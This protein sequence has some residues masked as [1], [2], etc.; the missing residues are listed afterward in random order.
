MKKKKISSWCGKVC[1]EVNGPS[2]V[3]EFL[4]DPKKV[5]GIHLDLS[6]EH[7]SFIP[8]SLAKKKKQKKNKKTLIYHQSQTSQGCTWSIIKTGNLLQICWEK[9]MQ[10]W[11]MLLRY[12][13]IMLRYRKATSNCI[14]NNGQPPILEICF[15]C[16]FF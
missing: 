8:A 15:L 14:C 6:G 13:R 9:N 7:K 3:A 11:T 2:C 12:K 5:I 1:V 4:Q 10:C 16:T